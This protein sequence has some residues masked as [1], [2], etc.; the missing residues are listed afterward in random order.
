MSVNIQKADLLLRM[1][2]DGSASFETT[3]VDLRSY[4][5]VQMVI[6]Y[7]AD[8]SA[9][10][11][12]RVIPTIYPGGFPMAMSTG[13]TAGAY[14]AGIIGLESPTGVA[15]PTTLTNGAIAINTAGAKHWFWRMTNPPPFFRLKYT[16][17]GGNRQFLWTV[18][19]RAG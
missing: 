5:D 17:A 18:H 3:E 12:L 13:P 1:P 9:G 19:G 4:S 15:A 16:R 14:W 7:G 6:E 10:D 2:L 11:T 8:A